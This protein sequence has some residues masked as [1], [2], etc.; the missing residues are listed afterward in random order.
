MSVSTN[1]P[2]PGGQGRLLDCYSTTPGGTLYATTP[3]GTRIIYDRKFLLE[4]KN[5]PIARTPPCYLP[6]IP[7]VTVPPQAPLA[8]LE[9]LKEQ[10]ETEIPGKEALQGM[11]K[12]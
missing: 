11:L 3:G 10:K 6:H 4:C 8:K 5:S 12:P 7:G 2:V 1:C 9:D